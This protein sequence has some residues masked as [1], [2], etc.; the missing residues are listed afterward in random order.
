MLIS[1]PRIELSKFYIDKSEEDSGHPFL[2]VQIFVDTRLF[3]NTMIFKDHLSELKI[4]NIG[5]SSA[6][7]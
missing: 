1:I 5:Q 4:I 3:S 6:Q 7:L 2:G